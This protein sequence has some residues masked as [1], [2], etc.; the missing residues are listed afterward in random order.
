MGVC[1]REISSIYGSP[2]AMY[3]HHSEGVIPP[4][5]NGKSIVDLKDVHTHEDTAKAIAELR[6][7]FPEMDRERRS[8]LFEARPSNSSCLIMPRSDPKIS[9]SF[10]LL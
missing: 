10:F 2:E 7:L 6:T 8:H 1:S 9:C 3:L 5:S 4:T